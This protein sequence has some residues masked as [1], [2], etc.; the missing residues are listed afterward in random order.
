MFLANPFGITEMNSSGSVP[1]GYSS[2]GY[3]PGSGE[4]GAD[5][6]ALSQTTE[7]QWKAVKEPW[8]WG[9]AD[10]TPPGSPRVSVAGGEVS[11][12]RPVLK[13]WVFVGYWFINGRKYSEYAS[14]TEFASLVQDASEPDPNT[15]PPPAFTPQERR[16]L[17][18]KFSRELAKSADAA[19][20]EGRVPPANGLGAATIPSA[21][22][23]SL[24]DS[25]LAPA[26]PR[27]APTTV[28]PFQTTRDITVVGDPNEK[29][30]FDREVSDP[31][32]LEAIE[33]RGHPQWGDV[34]QFAKGGYNGL[35]NIL[36]LIAGPVFGRIVEEVHLPQADIDPRYGGSAIVG[37]Q[38]VENLALEAAAGLPALGRI[39]GS[40]LKSERVISAVKAPAFWALGA[41]GVG[42]G[43]APGQR[44]AFTALNAV[45]ELPALGA[46]LENTIPPVTEG[47]VKIVRPDSKAMREQ[48][49][50]SA[51]F[52]RSFSYKGSSIVVEEYRA[53]GLNF[54][55][56]SELGEELT[57]LEEFKGD[58]S[59]SIASGNAGV[60][61]RLVKQATEQLEIAESLGVPLNWHIEK[62]QE[63]A[64]RYVLG[65]LADR[66][67][68]KTR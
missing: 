43:I 28:P 58:Y 49:L 47:W 54:D 42:G 20:N 53:G 23:P 2:F 5:P 52:D 31:A 27:P 21:S 45:N 61:N 30:P 1:F 24:G 17:Q 25:R 65:S 10:T 37:E 7:E 59:G 18:E 36:P 3:S 29:A 62:A 63:H 16:A 33:G 12:E 8:A 34:K 39:L 50:W 4:F 15:P 57:A 55:A 51:K 40:A 6:G 68:F 26:P 48:A 38:L 44:R 66:I 32:V 11:P 64:F 19:L 41:G 60:A 9:K 67:N 56:A 22:H 35:V 46:E 14:T 13:Q